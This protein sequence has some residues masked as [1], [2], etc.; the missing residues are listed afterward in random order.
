[1]ERVK[2]G[3]ECHINRLQL[4]SARAESL[5][6]RDASRWTLE[7]M[8]ALAL[9]WLARGRLRTEGIVTPVVSVEKS[10]DAYR[11][12]GSRAR[13]APSSERSGVRSR[14]L[15]VRSQGSGVRSQGLGG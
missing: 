15:G 14:G 3:D 10:A 8:V 11:M 7:R 6:L 2:C 1:M 12:E 4:I 13:E 9:D 5:P